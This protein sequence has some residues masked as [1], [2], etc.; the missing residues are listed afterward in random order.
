[1]PPALRRQFPVQGRVL[2]RLPRTTKQSLQAYFTYKEAVDKYGFSP[3]KYDL[4]VR[5]P[6]HT[7]VCAPHPRGWGACAASRPPKA[8]VAAPPPLPPPPVH[9]ALPA[10]VRLPARLPARPA[11]PPGGGAV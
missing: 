1:M 9:A 10:L 11:L 5:L 4:T 7:R 2:G 8:V 6:P 3:A